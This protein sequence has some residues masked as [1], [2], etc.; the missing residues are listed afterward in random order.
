MNSVL[1]KLDKSRFYKT[2]N[3]KKD[4]IYISKIP[5]EER[6]IKTSELSDYEL[7]SM[8]TSNGKKSINT[9]LSFGVF[10]PAE[11]NPQYETDTLCYV[12]YGEFLSFI[13]KSKA[14][15]KL[16]TQFES[17]LNQHSIILVTDFYDIVTYDA[18][19]ENTTVWSD[20]PEYVRERCLLQSMTAE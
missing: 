8:Y 9:G 3:T 5:L 18:S 13:K 10:I 11:L 20:L 17:L 15:K 16:T 4:S 6:Y 14:Y 7:I 1:N 12:S 2:G 19:N